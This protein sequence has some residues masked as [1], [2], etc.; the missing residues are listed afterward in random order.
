MSS[1]I[2]NENRIELEPTVVALYID[3]DGF[4]IKFIG[5]ALNNNQNIVAIECDSE[6]KALAAIDKYKPS[7]LFLD[8]SL[9]SGGNEGFEVVNKIK[10]RKIDIYSISSY[11]D[12][13]IE[14]GDRIKGIIAKND[15]MEIERIINKFITDNKKQ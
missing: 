12:A 5:H 8:N 2:N 4:M 13:F 11:P 15:Y 6:E 1:E 14:H 9:T 10:D 7:V 3:N